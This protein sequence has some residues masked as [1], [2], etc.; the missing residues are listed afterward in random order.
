MGRGGESAKVRFE[1]LRVRCDGPK[2]R[3]RDHRT[4]APSQWTLAPRTVVPSHCASIY[5]SVE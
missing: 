3:R 1:G 2:A 4:I 5:L